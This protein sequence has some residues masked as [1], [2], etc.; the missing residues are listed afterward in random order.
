MPGCEARSSLHR[1]PPLTT[2]TPLATTQRIVSRT[3][4]T[5]KKVAA[6]RGR[7]LRASSPQCGTS[8]QIVAKWNT[9]LAAAQ[10]ICKRASDA[11]WRIS[12]A[13]HSGR[14]HECY[15]TW[16]L[17]PDQWLGLPRQEFICRSPH[18]DILKINTYE[19]HL[20]DGRAS[21]A[22]LWQRTPTRPHK[23]I[24]SSRTPPRKYFRAIEQTLRPR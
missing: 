8:S 11:T 16:L 2:C 21:A 19:Q 10:R 4:C 5:K 15:A 1:G 22:S 13:F 9:A 24:C 17:L 18:G 14:L 6:H 20:Y 23:R 3:H 12:V 7:H